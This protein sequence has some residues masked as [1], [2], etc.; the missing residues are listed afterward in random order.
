MNRI[1]FCVLAFLAAGCATSGTSSPETPP[2]APNPAAEIVGGP[3]GG[4]KVGGWY[5]TRTNLRITDKNIWL[6]YESWLSG[7]VLPIGTKVNVVG[8]AKSDT[9]WELRTESGATYWILVGYGGI[10]KAPDQEIQKFLTATDPRP[11]FDAGSGEIAAGLQYGRPAM[12]MTKAQVV[13]A[14][15]F[16]PQIQDLNVSNRW[17]YPQAGRGWRGR[18]W[19]GWGAG[20]AHHRVGVEFEGGVVVRITGFEND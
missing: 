17:E 18:E 3:A 5:W 10:Y 14:L 19:R 2:A 11:G 8:T 12:G 6:T 1:P 9:R 7:D 4:I 15:G 20:A 13:A 16:P